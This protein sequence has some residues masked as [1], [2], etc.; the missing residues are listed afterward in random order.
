MPGNILRTL[1]YKRVIKPKTCRRCRNHGIVFPLQ[2]HS[3]KCEFNNCNCQ[4]CQ[5]TLDH[6]RRYE[7]RTI[8]IQYKLFKKQNCLTCE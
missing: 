1:K 5:L 6:Q 3:T 2:G 4:L 8:Q 7:F